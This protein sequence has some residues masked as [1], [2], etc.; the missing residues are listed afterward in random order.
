MTGLVSGYRPPMG[1]YD[2]MMD[3]KGE[4]RPHWRPFIKRLAAESSGSISQRFETA[5]QALRDSGVFYRVYDDPAAAD[6]PWPLS[7]IPILIDPADWRFIEK[8]VIQRARLIEALLADCYGKGS[9][10]ARG[11]LPAAA[12]AGSPD[13]LRPLVGTGSQRQLTVYA[14]DLGRSPTGQWWV[15]RD[16]TQAP[17]GAGYAVENRIALSRA[18]SDIYRSLDVERLAPFFDRLR[19]EFAAR[20]E[21]DDVGVCLLSPGPLNET[22]FEHAYLARYLGLRL[23]EGC[24][25]VVQNDAVY[26]RTIA[27]LRRVH[28][29]IRRVDGDFT[30]PLELDQRSQLGVPG[31]VQ[32]ARK[33][34]VV[35]ANALGSGLAEARALLGFLPALAEHLIGEPLLI[36]NVATWWCGD[37]AAR[38]EVLSR[39]DEF[40]IAPA[41][42]RQGG[43]DLA[44][45]PW[46][47]ARE[48]AAMHADLRSA[49]ERRGVDFVAQEPVVLSTT[50]VWQNGHLVPHPFM[51]RVFVLATDDGYKVMPGGFALIGDNSDVKAV[52]MQR[53]AR[54]ADVWVLSE[55][56]VVHSSLLSTEKDI[57]VRRASGALPSRAADNLFWLARYIERTEA[58][59]RLVRAL[60]SRLAERRDVDRPDIMGLAEILFRWGATNLAPTRANLGA[61]AHQALTSTTLDGAV[62]TLVRSARRTASVIRDRFPPDAWRALE[63]LER[64]A[65][66]PTASG[67]ADSIVYAR[68]TRALR[69]IAAVTGYQLEN[70]N[71]LSGWRF[72]KLGLRT[73]RAISICRYVRQLAGQQTASPEA[74][75]LLLELDDTQI[76]YR[77][78]YPMGAAMAPVLDLVLLDDSNPRSL[79]FQLGRIVEHVAALPPLPPDATPTPAL[80]IAE[81]L[82]AKVAAFDTHAVA[83]EQVLAIENAL[84]QL[85]DEIAESFFRGRELALPQKERT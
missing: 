45:A 65:F 7:H 61:I 33:G 56:P 32:A 11:Q 51:F 28:A 43:G 67:L 1:V 74:L 71:R 38:K 57:K 35:V 15:I 46:V 66:R 12:V 72:L 36:P 13:F 63:D 34:E 62:P 42:Q 10:V 16:R 78:R 41:F 76:T 22:Y 27:G 44:G 53:G 49:I 58:T 5:D 75:D 9:L 83:A 47:M 3:A 8:G 37:R 84:M 18:M 2:E 79:M 54:S 26:L 24:D 77:V 68:V 64:D 48:G 40:V 31:L 81:A 52:S 39:L 25:L 30:D 55:G 80:A 4:I 6:R 23:V 69:G 60:S 59:L 85:S 70:M 73:E 29:L 82:H 14:V 17:S 50:P 21:P 20:R 19:I